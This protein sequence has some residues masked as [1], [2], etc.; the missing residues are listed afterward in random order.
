MAERRKRLTE[1]LSEVD[2]HLESGEPVN[3]ELAAP[4]HAALGNVRQAIETPS[5]DDED[6]GELTEALGDLALNLEVSHPKLTELLNRIAD[7]LAG[8]G[9]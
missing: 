9:I 1:K 5:A 7:L 6:H 4:L 3:T 8:A 2:E